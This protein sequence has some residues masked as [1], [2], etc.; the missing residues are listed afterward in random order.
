M[1]FSS[2]RR[3]LS[4]F[5]LRIGAR[6]KELRIHRGLTLSEFG[7]ALDVSFQQIQKYERG[8]NS[9][10]VEKLLRASQILHVTLD[11]FWKTTGEECDDMPKSGDRG[12]IALVKAYK[13]IT[14]PAIRQKLLEVVKKIAEADALINGE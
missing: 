11:T 12:A 10:T 2:R 13:G 4:P 7:R 6:M 1:P 9:V 14:N 8:L 3:K 5:N